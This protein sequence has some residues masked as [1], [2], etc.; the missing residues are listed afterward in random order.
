MYGKGRKMVG[1]KC[2][3][4]AEDGVEWCEMGRRAGQGRAGQGKVRQGKAEKDIGLCG[5]GKSKVGHGMT[6]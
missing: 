2:L 6:G 3:G 1:G 4:K 5:T